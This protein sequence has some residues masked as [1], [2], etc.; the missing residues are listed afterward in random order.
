MKA[1]IHWY[2]CSDDKLET[3]VGGYVI[4]IVRGNMLIEIQ[5]R[6]FSVVKAKLTDLFGHNP[7]GWCILSHRGNGLFGLSR[8]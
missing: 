6:N 5:T 1:C 4:D 3:E 2:A 8:W 7:Y